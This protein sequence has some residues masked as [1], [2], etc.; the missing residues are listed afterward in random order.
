MKVRDVMKKTPVVIGETDTLGTA[1]ELMELFHIR[2]LPVCD[3][4]RLIGMLS[5]HDLLLARSRAPVGE[6]WWVERVAAAMQ[7]PARTAHPDDPMVEIAARMAADKVD[8][9]PVVE[10]GHLLGIVSVI[11]VLD[12]EVR[13]A[14]AASP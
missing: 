6:P 13:T 10:R 3:E 9:L 11:D 7:A 5:E 4:G 12:A 8:A 14:M 2:H 1:H